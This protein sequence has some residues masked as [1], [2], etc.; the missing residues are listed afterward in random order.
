MS[1]DIDLIDPKTNEPVKNSKML[2]IQS[3]FVEIV[4]NKVQSVKVEKH[5]EGGTYALGGT[6]E[7]SLN[8]TY[9]YSRHF[10]EHIDSKQG[11]RWLYGKTGK[12]T[13]ERLT[14]AV[15]ELGT[16]KDADYWKDT[17]G[18]AGYALSILLKWAIQHPT[19]VFRGD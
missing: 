10:Y 5:E 11:I 15:A 16:E 17:P 1:Y 7:A 18:N 6:E 13:Q 8:I 3:N 14:K 9:N 19:A 12:E 4:E 2:F